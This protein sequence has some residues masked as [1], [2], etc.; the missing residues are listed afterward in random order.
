VSVS[1]EFLRLFTIQQLS[2]GSVAQFSDRAEVS[3]VVCLDKFCSHFLKTSRNCKRHE[4]LAA[5]VDPG[6]SV[7]SFIRSAW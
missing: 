7:R 5:K 3:P 4:T 6:R 2:N 1:A